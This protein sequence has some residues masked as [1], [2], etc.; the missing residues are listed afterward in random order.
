MMIGQRDMRP[1]L[2]FVLLH[3]EVLQSPIRIKVISARLALLLS[4]LAALPP[5]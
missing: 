5:H 2:S 1:I 3:K 4:P